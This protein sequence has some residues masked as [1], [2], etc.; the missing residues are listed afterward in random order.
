MIQIENLIL[1][2]QKDIIL[3]IENLKLDKGRKI[4]LVGDNDS[5]KSILIK[6]LHGSYHHFKGNILF[7]DRAR[8]FP[9]KKEHSLLVDNTCQVLNDENVWKNLTLPW[10]EI[11]ATRKQKMLDLCKIAGLQ[12]NLSIKLGL[13]SFSAQKM[14]ELIR[15]AVQLPLLLLLD[16]FDNYFDAKKEEIALEI[17]NYAV[18]SGSTV[19]ATSKRLLTGFDQTF[20]I[21]NNR[22]VSL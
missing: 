16:D 21:Q 8:L 15:A 10:S 11:S 19:L 13:L 3:T 6:T 18:N 12:E 17:C 9:R 7:N 4:L 2:R 22:V 1:N 5:G 14:V 20:R